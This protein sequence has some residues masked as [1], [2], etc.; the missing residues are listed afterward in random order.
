MAT[1]NL[2]GAGTIGLSSEV[3]RLIVNVTAFASN[4]TIGRATPANYYD[5][6]LLRFGV[7]GAFGPT[8]AIDATTMFLDAPEG[9][10]TLGYSLFGTTA[11]TVTEQFGSFAPGGVRV[12]NMFSQVLVNADG[13]SHPQLTYT[14]PSGSSALVEAV[15]LAVGLGTSTNT[16]GLT[17]SF[18]GNT[19]YYEGVT[20]PLPTATEGSYWA[21][22]SQAAG[23]HMNAGETLSN[24]VAIGN[25]SATG[26]AVITNFVILQYPQA[27]W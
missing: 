2:T 14:V 26:L 25:G 19:L 11:V 10:T 27:M 4:R 17:L 15:F 7:Q 23:L 21:V 1:Y 3:S 13:A 20:G 16:V 9:V 6:G 5:L 12:P 18:N 22:T 24:A 8:I